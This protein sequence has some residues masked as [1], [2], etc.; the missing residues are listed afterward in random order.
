MKA[1]VCKEFGGPDKLELVEVSSLDPLDDEV[2]IDVKASGLNFPDTLIIQGLYQF[3]PELPFSPGGEVAGIIKSVGQEVKHLKVGDRVVSGTS[4]GGFAEE[5]RGL[6][7]NTYMIPDQMSFKE[8]AGSLM[9][10]ATVYH[11]LVDRGQL[12]PKETLMILGAAGGVGTAAIQIGKLLGAKVI[13]CASSSEKLAYCKALGADE[14]I[15]YSIDSVKTTSKDLT[16]GVG[17]DMVFDPVGGPNAELAFRSIARGGRYLVV[18]FASGSIPKIPWNLPLLKSASIV[19]VFWGGFFRN[20][21]EKNRTNVS[22]LLEWFDQ[23]KLKSE[24][25]KTY[26]LSEYAEAYDCLIQKEV[27]GKV[28]LVVE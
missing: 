17:V 20:E 23:G 2:I 22:Q 19:G 10:Y 16:K 3:Q 28:V 18:G 14:C 13:A 26:K 15:N 4:W 6:A 1:V 9:T 5:A 21:P 7:S 25:H 8:A 27:K 12:R 24:I 11:A